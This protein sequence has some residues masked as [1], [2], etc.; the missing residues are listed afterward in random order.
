MDKQEKSARRS[1]TE[2]YPLIKAYESSGLSRQ[3]FCLEHGLKASTFSYWRSKYLARDEES[4]SGF[5]SLVPDGL[6]SGEITLEYGG[7]TL[8]MGKEVTADYVA[9]LVHKLSGRC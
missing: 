3:E 7:V 6:P 1:A 9:S 4:V 2:M 5:V 8:R